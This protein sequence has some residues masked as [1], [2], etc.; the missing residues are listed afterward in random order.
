MKTEFKTIEKLVRED[1]KLME[2]ELMVTPE[3]LKTFAARC[4]KN[5][6]KFNDWIRQLAYDALAD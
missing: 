5:D 1:A 3:E 6:V 2:I 4:I